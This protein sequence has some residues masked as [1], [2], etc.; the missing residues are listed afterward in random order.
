MSTTKGRCRS[1]IRSL[2][3]LSVFVLCPG[4]QAVRG[5]AVEAAFAE[6]ARYLADLA[7]AYEHGEGVARDPQHAAVLYCEAAR[8]GNAEAAYALGW[9]YANG[10]GLPRD[11]TYASA[12]FSIAAEQGNPHAETMLRFTGETVVRPACLETPPELFIDSA[13]NLE[14]RL[15]RLTP[16]QRVVAELIVELAPKYQISPSFA[17]AIALT[18]SALNPRAVSPK[19]AQG[20]MQLIPDTAARFNVRNVF[21]P[22]DN[23]KGGLS[24]LRWLLAYFEGDVALAAAAYNAGERAVERYKGVP[25]FKETQDYVSRILS[26]VQRHAHPYDRSVV[27]PSPVFVALRTAASEAG[28]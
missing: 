2:V 19:N 3:A 8:L 22:G 7:L 21:D 4:A 14:A 26:M 5:E 28:R 15:R 18:E 27:D 9:M 25:P 11:D 6:H 16:E 20:V 1:G 12:F 24:Y 10:R 13:W 23:I 17:L